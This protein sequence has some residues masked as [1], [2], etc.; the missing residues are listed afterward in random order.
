M[1]RSSGPRFRGERQKERER[2][3]EREIERGGIDG[4]CE[5]ERVRERRTERERAPPSFSPDLS[6]SLSLSLR[7][8]ELKQTRSERNAL[9][10]DEKIAQVG[11]NQPVKI[12]GD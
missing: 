11:P 8:R 9:A 1:V 5:K 12:L 10:L 6:L 4:V 7:A 2:E 3:R